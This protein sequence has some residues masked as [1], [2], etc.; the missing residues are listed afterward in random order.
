MDTPRFEASTQVG[1][2][3]REVPLAVDVFEALDI[4]YACRGGRPLRD[5]AM[6]AGVSPEEALV[7]LRA[8]SGDGAAAPEQSIAQLLERIVTEH[9]RFDAALFR[10]ARSR[11]DGLGHSAAAMRIRRLLEAVQTTMTTH[12]LREERD[13]FPR[14]EE[15]E[16]HP[17]RVRGGSVSNPLLIEFVEHDT[18]HEWLTKIRE[19][20]L[21][22]RL[23][24][25]DLASLES[26]ETLDRSLHR[27]L[28]LENNVLIPRVIDLE[29][30]HRPARHAG[31]REMS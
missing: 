31:S 30:R 3:A 8:A 18:V 19:L 11:L 6:A 9:H 1:H 24:G 4:E 27:H 13:L 16:L 14:L 20:A 5:A 10:T 22:L 23:E 12:M 29:N 17:D 15:I 28:H 21:R 25:A 2:I 7:S 26:L